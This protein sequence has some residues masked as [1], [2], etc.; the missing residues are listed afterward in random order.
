[1]GTES[2]REREREQGRGQVLLSLIHRRRGFR[3]RFCFLGTH[4]LPPPPLSLSLSLPDFSFY[5]RHLFYIC[6]KP[7]WLPYSIVYIKFHNLGT[8][9]RCPHNVYERLREITVAFLSPKLKQRFCCHRGNK[10]CHG[11]V[12]RTGVDRTGGPRLSIALDSRIPIF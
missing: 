6:L 4:S 2:V 3:F 9:Y 1:M 7:P 12:H 11:P 10:A 8:T 5:T